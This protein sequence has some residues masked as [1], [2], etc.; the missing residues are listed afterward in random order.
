MGRKAVLG[1]TLVVLGLISWLS[2]GAPAGAERLQA[3]VTVV[4]SAA[5]TLTLDDSEIALG[6]GQPGETVSDSISGSV[7]SNVP[8]RLTYKASDFSDGT[9]SIPVS[10]VKLNGTD[11]GTPVVLGY[12]G[13]VYDNMQ[14]T[15]E[16][17]FKFEHTFSLAIPGDTKP[18]TY[19]AYI[20]YTVTQIP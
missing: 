4:E 10:C 2:S 15:P 11:L 17:G 6:N 1:V 16:T 7:A 18:G 13:K 3:S 14:P 12:S 20:E 5:I 8:W 19:N 9:N